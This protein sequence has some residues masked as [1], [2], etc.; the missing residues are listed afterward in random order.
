MCGAEGIADCAVVD[1]VMAA[2]Q[3][4]QHLSRV[5]TDVLPCVSLEQAVVELHETGVAAIA[6]AVQFLSLSGH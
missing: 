4:E 5:G 3:V 6:E 1:T 2:P